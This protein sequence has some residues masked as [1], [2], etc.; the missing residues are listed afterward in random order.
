MHP[1]KLP[2]GETG[3]GLAVVADEISELSDQ[4][5]SSIKVID[6]LIKADIEKIGHGIETTEDT[7]SAIV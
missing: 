4:T 3:R 6:S 2:A 5:V 7:V 1:L